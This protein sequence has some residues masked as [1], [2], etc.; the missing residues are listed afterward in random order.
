MSNEW[1]EAIEDHFKVE[2]MA[3][4]GRREGSGRKKIS[5]DTVIVAFKISQAEWDSVPGVKSEFTR[6]AI[7]EKMERENVAIKP[8]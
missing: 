4:G 1:K 8:R 3:N 7:R 6:S 5:D 2:K